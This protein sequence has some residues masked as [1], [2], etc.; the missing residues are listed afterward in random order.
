MKSRSSN[1]G[2]ILIEDDIKRMKMLLGLPVKYQGMNTTYQCE[3]IYQ[4][5][6][7]EE[8]GSAAG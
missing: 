3:V 8:C 7:T 6:N 5:I 1:L 2:T 4:M